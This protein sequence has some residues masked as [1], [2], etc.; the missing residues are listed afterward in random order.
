[1]NNNGI[2]ILLYPTLLVDLKLLVILVSMLS[3]LWYWFCT[4]FSIILFIPFFLYIIQIACL[5]KLPKDFPKSVVYT[6]SFSVVAIS[7]SAIYCITIFTITVKAGNFVKNIIILGCLNWRN[8]WFVNNTLQKLWF[9]GDSF[10]EL[11]VRLYNKIYFQKKYISVVLIQYK[12]YIQFII[13]F[14]TARF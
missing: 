1:M 3:I 9:D 2:R 5:H 12:C 11:C 13:V 4:I 8:N 6:K 10:C 14:I 7:I